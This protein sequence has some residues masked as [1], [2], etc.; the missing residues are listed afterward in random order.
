M[1]GMDAELDLLH[2]YKPIDIESSSQIDTLR[3]LSAIVV[4]SAHSFQI[5]IAPVN[6][7]IYGVLGLIAQAAV[8]LFFVLSGFL[9]TKSITRRYSSGFSL[10]AYASDRANRIVPPLLV[11]LAICIILWAIAPFFFASKSTDFL[12]AGPFMARTGFDVEIISVIGSVA[13][14]NGFL[15]KNIGANAPLWS[16]P[17]EVW[18]YL[19]AGIIAYCRGRKGLFIAAIFLVA[20]GSLNKFFLLYSLVWFAGSGICIAHNNSYKL[21]KLSAISSLIFLPIGLAIGSYYLYTLTKIEHPSQINMKVVALYNVM[22]GLFFAT[23]LL[24]ILNGK[25]K[26]STRFANSAAFSY[27]LYVI[28]FPII[29]FAYGALQEQVKSMFWAGCAALASI[30]VCIAV[31]R[32]TAKFAESARIFPLRYSAIS[33]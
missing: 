7:S 1:K 5:F 16:L 12:Y 24:M 17:F 33:K 11:S 14:L 9:I 27:T 22:I 15:V 32:Y 13:F 26:I 18:Y 21:L 28:H 23:V 20:L 8:M 6:H 31:A 29:L 10:S 2:S 19:A 3:G 25:I 30:F 4:M